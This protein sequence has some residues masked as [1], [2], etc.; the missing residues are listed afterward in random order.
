MVASSSKKHCAVPKLHHAVAS[1]LSRLFAKS[2]QVSGPAAFSFTR[3]QPRSVSKV[4]TL[5]VTAAEQS[6]NFQA[7]PYTGQARSDI[8]V[9]GK[10]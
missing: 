2:N 6:Q 3:Q 7:V 1:W 9:G 8:E 10:A 4:I 5:S